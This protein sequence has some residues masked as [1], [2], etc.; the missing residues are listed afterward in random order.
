MSGREV[1]ELRS[2]IAKLTGRTP[3]STNETYLTRRLADL[4]SSPPAPRSPSDAPVISVSVSAA[5]REAIIAIAAEELIGVSELVRR[6][7]GEY[8]R[9]RGHQDLASAIEVSG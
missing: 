1:R 3:V 2:E 5:A 6:A 4:R 7:I 9:R 8:A